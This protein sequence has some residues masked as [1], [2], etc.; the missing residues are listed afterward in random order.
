[1][2]SIDFRT[3]EIYL[4]TPYEPEVIP[5]TDWKVVNEMKSNGVDSVKFEFRYKI[6]P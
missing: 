3:E 5:F 1:V 4:V 2:H 6:T